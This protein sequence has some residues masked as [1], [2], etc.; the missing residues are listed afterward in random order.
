[1]RSTGIQ[2]LLTKTRR[3]M[4]GT[5]KDS[6][7]LQVRKNR[8]KRHLAPVDE[9]S[10]DMKEPLL[11]PRGKVFHSWSSAMSGLQS[12]G[13][14]PWAGFTTQKLLWAAYRQTLQSTVC[15]TCSPI[16]SMCDVIVSRGQA[17]T[18]SNE[19][20]ESRQPSTATSLLLALDARP[21]E[22]QTASESLSR[23]KTMTRLF[24][25]LVQGVHQCYNH[26]LYA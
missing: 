3:P 5:G 17:L 6:S 12:S 16:A 8:T 1:M 21:L 26:R 4:L 22:R 2:V 15:C 13:Q 9:H 20:H 14:G 7:Y 10:I 25:V 23:R 24:R 11:R 19:G 18:I